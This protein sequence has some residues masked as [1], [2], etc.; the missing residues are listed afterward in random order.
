M[1][2]RPNADCKVL[3]LSNRLVIPRGRQIFE[4]ILT[5]NFHIY[6]NLDVSPNFPLLCDQL[7]ESEFE[8]QMWM[9]FDC[10][11]QLMATGDAYPSKV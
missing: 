1:F 10:N 4:L 8:S 3:P 6:K 9:L 7:Y 2:Y 5:Y 11:K